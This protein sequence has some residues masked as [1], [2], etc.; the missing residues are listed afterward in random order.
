[1][2]AAGGRGR[3]RRA[4]P[5]PARRRPSPS[6]SGIRAHAAAASPRPGPRRRRAPRGR[7]NSGTGS[8]PSDTCR[9]CCCCCCTPCCSSWLTVSAGT[10]LCGGSGVLSGAAGGEGEGEGFTVSSVRRAARSRRG[11]GKGAA[12]A[13]GSL[14]GW[15]GLRP[16]R[17][18][19]RGAGVD[20]PQA[21]SGSAVGAGK[22]RKPLLPPRPTRRE[23][24]CS[25]SRS[26]R[27]PGSCRS[28][29][30]WRRG[31]ACRCRVG[32]TR[33]ASWGRSVSPRVAP[34]PRPTAGH[35]SLLPRPQL[36]LP[37]SP[38]M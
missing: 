10:L 16:R 29:L 12:A 11:R 23:A 25:G 4:G 17:G 28:E 34:G 14:G 3:A 26:L 33:P 38:K 20:A 35:A 36:H 1:M 8:A 13:P 7:W 21:S 30:C 18:G 37:K 15:P 6:A 22:T 27:R 9:R 19:L 2:A 32:S 31:H 24:A 5:W